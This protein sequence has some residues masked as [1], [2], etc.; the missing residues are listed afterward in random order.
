MARPKKAAKAKTPDTAPEIAEEPKPTYNHD[1]KKRCEARDR[2]RPAFLG[3]KCGA[4]MKPI[5][6]RD[7]GRLKT[8]Q[9]PTCGVKVVTTGTE[10]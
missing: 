10:I 3:T 7:G 9:C 2:K 6:T 5:L 1:T 4:L 8:W